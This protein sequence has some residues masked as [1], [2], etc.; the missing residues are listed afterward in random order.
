MEIISI[1]NEQIKNRFIANSTIEAINEKVRLITKEFILVLVAVAI[2]VVLAL[3]SFPTDRRI[4]DCSIAEISPD[5]TNAMKEAC[6]KERM[7]Q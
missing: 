7:A 1:L 4:I 3:Y 6:R 5:Y 2:A